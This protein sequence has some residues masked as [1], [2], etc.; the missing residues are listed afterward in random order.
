MILAARPASMAEAAT[1]L[2]DSE[3]TKPVADYLKTFTPLSVE[4]ARALIEGLRSLDNLKL[5]ETHLVKCADFLPRDAEDVHKVV[6]DVSLTESEV[7]AILDV[8]KNY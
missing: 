2:A 6:H 5:K 3:T 1:L 4:K 8:V 7:T